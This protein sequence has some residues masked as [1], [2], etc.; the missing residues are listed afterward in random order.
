MGKIKKKFARVVTLVLVLSGIL[1]PSIHAEAATQENVW[2]GYAVNNLNNS[3][4][5]YGS[6]IVRDVPIDEGQN[7][8]GIIKVDVSNLIN[9]V[10]FKVGGNITR[11]DDATLN[12]AYYVYD[13]V[14]YVLN[15]NYSS[16]CELINSNFTHTIAGSDVTAMKTDAIDK[17]QTEI[18]L[19]FN[20]TTGDTYTFASAHYELPVP[21]ENGVDTY[22]SRGLTAGNAYFVDQSIITVESSDSSNVT[23]KV[24][25]APTA[26]E[27][28][29]SISVSNFTSG[30]DLKLHLTSGS[31]IVATASN[32]RES[33]YVFNNVV[34]N[35]ANYYVTQTINGVEGIKSNDITPTLR[36]PVVNAGAGYV[37][38]S[39]IYPCSTAKLY[40]TS[41]ASIAI[42]PTANGDGTYRFS[43]LA[44]GTSYYVRQSIN[45]VVS[46]A[47]SIVNVLT[48]QAPTAIAE[49]ERISVS[50]F[51]FGADLKLYL[52][53]GSA[54]VATASNVRESIHIFN[55]IVPNSANYYVTQTLNGVEGIK[56][57]AITPTL[58]TPIVHAGFDYVDVSNVYPCSTVKLYSTSGSSIAITPTSN[59]DGT[60]RFSDLE[61]GTSYYVKQSINGIVS[62]ASSIVNVL[63]PNAPT[64]TAGIE[65]ISVN[66]FTSGADLKLYLT[67][68]SAIVATASHV[69]E[70]VFVFN[71]IVPNS[72]NYYVTQTVNGVEGKKSNA[73]TPA[74]RTPV[75]QAGFGYV[76]VS[77]VYTGSTVQLYSTSGSSIAITPTSNGDGTY[78]F[79]GLTG[80]TSYYVRQS[81]NNVVSAASGIVSVLGPQ[82]P[83]AIAGIESISV[84]NYTSGADLKLY[85]TSGSAI[86]ATASHVR[87]PIHIFNNVVP[88]SAKYYVTQTV[89]GVEGTKSNA[90]TPTLRTPILHAGIG[91][92]DVSNV[93]TGAAI[94]LYTTSGSSIAVTPTS[95]GDGTYRFSG[96][97]EGTSYYVRQSINNVVSAASNIVTVS[98]PQA[99]T[100]IAGIESISVSNYTSGADLKLYLTSGSAIIATAS[101]VTEPIHI[102]NNVV[103]DSANYYVTQTVNG[104]EGTKSNAITPSL[105]TPIIHAG[106]DYVDVSNVYTGA[107]ITLYTTSGSSIVITPTSNGDGTYRFSDL[108]GGTP[109]FVRQSI[110]NVVSAD[111]NIVTVLAP[112]AP[113]AIAG[114]ES[115]SVSNF[116]SGADLKLC[117][118]SGSAI[119]AT[120]SNVTESTYIFNNVVPNSAN[121]YVT[122]IVN[123]VEGK[124][125]NDMTPA[126]RTPIVHA[127]AGYVDVS[128]VYPCSTIKLYSTS[129]SSIAITPTAN[130]DGTYRFSGLAGGTSYYARQSINNVISTASTVVTVSA[131]QTPTVIAGIESLSV[132]NFIFG[133]DL[134][135]YLTSGNVI[136]ATASNVRESI[137]IFD[138]IVPNSANY[139]VTQTANGLEGTKSKDITPTLRTPIIHAGA[140]YIDVSNVY[141]CSTVKLYSTSGASIAITPT[142]NGDGTYR[143]NDLE[144]GTSY[145]VKQ[146]INGVVSAM[147]NTVIVLEDD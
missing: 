94:T 66:N 69:K 75:V 8:F 45:D 119:I 44:G 114:I 125:S 34:P 137:H 30:A 95:N 144:S 41:G 133:A 43:G 23:V 96:L 122:Q 142:A 32:V 116:T 84:S 124:K 36:T 24:P 127:G 25:Q 107:T 138:N 126:L 105:R 50:N 26:I 146:S 53:S 74:L 15:D 106:F 37:D 98:A 21:I 13:G 40:S 61:S 68:G 67:S 20:F 76:D 2:Y 51:T 54:I 92:V 16:S 145:Y 47:S 14:N 62:A 33:V 18:F 22:Q 9:G 78:R 27:G 7:K 83:T 70:S 110:N 112:Q 104:V 100:V 99:P 89:N 73:I 109:Y 39:N 49:I 6:D 91:Y 10:P 143:F 97:T 123:G 71:N 35:S 134:K 12:V 38:V 72:A 60:Y 102:F 139:Y 58:G 79:S 130:G 59:G 115:I 93:Y 42:T 57:N 108:A 19:V 136:I 4:S 101:H 90:I 29:E 113:T 48:P 80:G 3:V 11:H 63:A 88:D 129:G 135:L 56:S 86:I 147:S 1:A 131:P 85:L 111:S 55:N 103:P 81:I 82:A 120:A 132:S 46:A 28:I 52:T 17:G 5:L 77:N 117:L 140:G 65:S 118:T 141:P 128:N 121:Y 64:A 31:A 87:E